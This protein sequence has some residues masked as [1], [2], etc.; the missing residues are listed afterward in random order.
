MRPYYDA[1][2]G[3]ITRR[4]LLDTGSGLGFEVQPQRRW[5]WT[6]EPL[7]VGSSM[8]IDGLQYTRAGRLDGQVQF[9]GNSYAYPILRVSDDTE[10]VGTDLLRDYSITFDQ[11]AQR[12]EVIPGSTFSNQP[13]VLRG[14]GAIF[15]PNADGMKVVRLV[16]GSP[17]ERVGMEIGDQV[18]RTAFLKRDHFELQ[19]VQS[20]SYYVRRGGRRFQLEVPV[21]DLI[22]LPRV[23]RAAIDELPFKREL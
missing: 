19:R 17:A 7:V 21:V 20:K 18:E 15:S 16:P 22:P 11:A 5:D 6:V 1:E 8:G 13:M 12:L 2:I 3:G 14:T 23:G 9:F 4:L 10:L